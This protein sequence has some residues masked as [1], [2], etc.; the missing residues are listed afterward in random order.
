MLPYFPLVA[1]P[2][3]SCLGHIKTHSK[4]AVCSDSQ[5]TIFTPIKI[6]P[7]LRVARWLRE[8]WLVGCEWL[9]SCEW[10]TGRSKKLRYGWLKMPC[11]TLEGAQ[12]WPVLSWIFLRLIESSS[13]IMYVGAF[14][15]LAGCSMS[16]EPTLRSFWLILNWKIFDLW[17]YK[18]TKFTPRINEMGG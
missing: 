16:S 3:R 9:E 4:T 7:C 6:L 10:L 1:S 11:W 15:S 8:L 12:R 18:Y 17:R 2:N 5:V 13:D 14:K